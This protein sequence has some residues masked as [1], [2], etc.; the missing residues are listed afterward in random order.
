MP[1]APLAIGGSVDPVTKRVIGGI[2][3][4]GLLSFLATNRF[5]GV[6]RGLNDFPEEN[7]PPL[8]I[9]TLFNVMVGIGTLLIMLSFGALGYRMIRKRAYP[10]WLLWLLVSTGPLSLIGI[11]T[12]WIFSCTGR[13][14]WTIY[15]I[16]RTADAA[17][18]AAN[19]GSLFVMF[20]SLYVSLLVITGVV[21]QY[22]FK[23]NP[24]T[25][26]LQG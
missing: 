8:F 6:V 5:D 19:L 24:V 2:E 14:P 21:M 4:P 26:E 3:I 10:R 18:N 23:R 11:E 25:R 17:T 13:Q 22:Y 15:H 20:L 12:G 9:H 16:Q 7:W 1:H